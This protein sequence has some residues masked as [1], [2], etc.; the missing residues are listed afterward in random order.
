VTDGP[1]KTALGGLVN[2]KP[3]WSF[4]FKGWIFAFLL[5][6]AFCV[7]AIR[8]VHPFL[9]V[10]APVPARTLVVEGWMADYEIPDLVGEF[11][12]G[13]YERV[14]T[15]GGEIHWGNAENYAEYSAKCL[16]KAGLPA[17]TIVPVA[18]TGK[19]WARTYQS[20]TALRKY[21]EDNKCV[22]TSLNVIT[23]GPHARRSRL[24]F[25]RALGHNVT[26]GVITLRREDYD[27]QH[28][29]RSSTGIRE[30][31]SELAAYL[32]CRIVPSAFAGS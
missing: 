1:I 20:A 26:V 28:W 13:N 7:G 15:T 17:S 27:E 29:W 31:I 24:L 21:F 22:P 2:R 16:N 8:L 6:V 3:R 10:Q 18:S 4:S 9:A 32:Y 23:L 19:D 5:A 14:Y 25:E 12:R 11:R 30:V